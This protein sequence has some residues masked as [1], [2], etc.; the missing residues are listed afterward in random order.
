MKMHYLLVVSL[1]GLFYL[2]TQASSAV[3]YCQN[4]GTGNI[5]CVNNCAPPVQ[6]NLKVTISTN[7]V[8]QSTIQEIVYNFTSPTIK[9]GDTISTL[10]DRQVSS[11]P[12]SRD[13]TLSL[14]VGICQYN[15]RAG[16]SIFI[17]NCRVRAYSDTPT[18]VNCANY[19][20]QTFKVSY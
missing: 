18:Q 14:P 2:M 6:N 4:D 1:G 9:G 7:P 3:S 8:N 12:L 17:S 11:F 20:T 13:Y 5:E 15:P 19:L 10:S 16:N